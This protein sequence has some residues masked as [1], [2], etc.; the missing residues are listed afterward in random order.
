LTMQE[1]QEHL[2]PFTDS[3]SRLTF[4]CGPDPML[5]YCCYPLLEEAYGEEF[6]SNNVFT[7]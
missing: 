3:K 2:F 1:L 5:K 7:F 6:C 4:L